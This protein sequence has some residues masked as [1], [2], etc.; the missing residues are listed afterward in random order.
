M[1][2]APIHRSVDHS[3]LYIQAISRARVHI[4]K[5][6]KWRLRPN[7]VTLPYMV[8][9]RYFRFHLC[10]GRR[11]ILTRCAGLIRKRSYTHI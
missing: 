4:F 5:V 1:I 6:P 11:E 3:A 7:D 2:I 10:V 9:K 8:I